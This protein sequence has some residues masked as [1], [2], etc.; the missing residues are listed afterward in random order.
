MTMTGTIQAPPDRRRRT[1][2]YV[3]AGLCAVEA[4]LYLGL[5]MAVRALEEGAGVETTW[6]LYLY[7]SVPFVIGVAVLLLLDDRAVYVLGAA[8]QGALVLLFVWASGALADYALLAGL[9]VPIGAW[10]AAITG[11]QLLLFGLLAYLAVTPVPTPVATT[12]GV[13][14]RLAV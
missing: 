13:G 4:L 3:G 9:T 2:R 10:A 7:G 12:G 6:G 1:L 14:R 11:V 8:L 5:M